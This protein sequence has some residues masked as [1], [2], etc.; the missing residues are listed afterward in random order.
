[1]AKKKKRGERRPGQPKNTAVTAEL[2]MVVAAHP[3]ADVTFVPELDV[4]KAALLY[5]DRVTLFSPLLTTFMRLEGV[6]RLT[7]QQQVDLARRVTPFI[8]D[9]PD[10]AVAYEQ[11]LRQMNEFLRRTQHSSSQPDVRQARAEVRKNW[12]RSSGSSPRSSTHS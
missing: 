11:G 3:T 10:E 9:D 7:I 12:H 2:R 4:V 5:G 1:M 8:F 6:E